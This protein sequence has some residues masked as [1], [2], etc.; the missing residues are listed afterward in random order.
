MKRLALALVVV[1]S[2]FAAAAFA[3]DAE[4]FDFNK[5]IAK[6]NPQA[7]AANRFM[8]RMPE[9][10]VSAVVVKDE[11][12]THDHNDGSHVLYIVSGHGTATVAGKAVA[13]KPGVVVHIPQGIVH[14]IKAERGKITFVDFV[15]HAFDPNQ[16][17]GNK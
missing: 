7:S 16:A 10:T 8:I 4:V 15:Q 5:E 12:P 17:G 1:T 9:Y 11:I 13:L 3:G 14:S 2:L 6:A